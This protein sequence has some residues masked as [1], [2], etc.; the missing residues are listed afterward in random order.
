MLN[1]VPLVRRVRGA[2]Y[3]W[4]VLAS[5][6]VLGTLSGGI[7]SNSSG[8]FFGPIQRDLGLNSAQTSLIFSLVR[9][10][11]SIAGPIV[12][13]L[14]DKFGSRPMIIFGGIL[15]SFGFIALH[16]VH[17]Y[18]LFIVIFVG[19]VGIGKSAGL[20]QVLVSAVNRWFIRRRSLAMSICITGFSSGGAAILPLI[21]LGVSTVGWRDVM[22]YSGI[23]MGLIVIPLASL[24]RYSPEH[25]GIGPD[26][27]FPKEGDSDSQ[28]PVVDFTVR[29]A[30]R[31]KSYWILF[32]GS[33]LRISLWGTISLH[34]VEMFVW[35]GMSHEM[36]GLMFS[37]MFLL[38]IPLRLLV[39]VLGDKFPLPP[40]MGAGMASAA[41]AAL[42]MLLIDGN[43]AVYL[44]VALMAIEQGTSTL[45]W[46]SLGNFFGRTSFAS[47]M[48]LISVAFNIGML[49]T[50]I[51][52]G[53]MFDRTGSYTVVLVSFLPIYFAAGAFF[54]MTRKP[55]AP[56][57]PGQ[58]FTEGRA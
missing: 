55:E 36:A 21:T 37:L 54:L 19:V 11:G 44:F 12:G 45:N 48:G 41:L 8:I 56:V 27:P 13:R 34:S 17:N 40:M 3:G 16:W 46:V 2:Y 42:A 7:F 23:F 47:L 58:R 24:V 33:V 49:I 1:Q 57:M 14:V 30:L 32:T 22:L 15:A 31:T 5:T 26:L 35:K 29:Q 10:E 43:L 6:F 50:P 38:S 53:L 4:W 52:A 39:G 20:G 28:P 18:V 25:M 9:A 51:Y